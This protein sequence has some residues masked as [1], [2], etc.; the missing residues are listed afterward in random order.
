MFATSRTVVLDHREIT[1]VLVT[2]AVF[3]GGVLA[4]AWLAA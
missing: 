3:L 4:L 1:A 2:S